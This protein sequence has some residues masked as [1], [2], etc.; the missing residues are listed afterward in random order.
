[1]IIDLR[2]DGNKYRQIELESAKSI[3]DIL[4]D[5]DIPADKILSFKIDH[6]QYVNEIYPSAQYANRLYHL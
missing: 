3:Q 5:T 1:M 2:L 6:T 4:K